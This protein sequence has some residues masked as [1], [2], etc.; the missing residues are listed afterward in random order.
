MKNIIVEEARDELKKGR[1]V[2]VGTASVEVSEILSKMLKRAGIHHN[3]LN[4][5]HHQKEA[6]IIASAGRKG[7]LTIATNMA[8]RGT[9]IKL[10]PEMTRDELTVSFADARGVKATQAP[11]FSLFL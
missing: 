9:D 5:K 2:L 10:D 7:A 3:V 8:G 6:D 11:H 4:A 1:A